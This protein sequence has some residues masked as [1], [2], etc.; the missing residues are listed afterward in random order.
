MHKSYEKV[1]E[2]KDFCGILMPFQ[3]DKMK[4]DKIPCII[5]ADLES[6]MEKNRWM[7]KQSK[8]SSTAKIVEHISCKY[9]L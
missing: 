3:Q 2:N 5:Y 4:S 7:C 6:L 1:C 8:K 9:S